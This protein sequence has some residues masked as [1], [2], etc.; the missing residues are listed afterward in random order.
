VGLPLFGRVVS[1]DW[2]EV[3]RF[4]GPSI[5]G[6]YRDHPLDEQLALWRRAGIGD[7]RARVMSLG[8]GVVIWGSKGGSDAG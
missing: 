8:G 1:R 6:L 2:F 4:L 5:E 3:G 7:V